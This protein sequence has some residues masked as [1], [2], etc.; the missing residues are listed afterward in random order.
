M[1]MFDNIKCSYKLP[2]EKGFSKEE[3]SGTMVRS[4]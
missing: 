4:L 2:I 3:Y 1:G